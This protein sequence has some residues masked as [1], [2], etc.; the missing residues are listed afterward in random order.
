MKNSFTPVGNAS[1]QFSRRWSGTQQSAIDPYITGYHF[2]HFAYIPDKLVNS[3]RYVPDPHK[4]SQKN[5][6]KSILHSSCLS[7]TLPTGTLNKAEFVGLGGQKYAVPTNVE[8]DN[9]FTI[10]FL[11]YSG[12]P[13]LAIMHAWVR[14]IRDYRAGVSTLDA[15]E[16]DY[17]K[18]NYAATMFYWTTQPNGLYVEEFECLTGVYPLKDPRDQYGHDITTYDKL[19]LDIDFNV[20]VMWHED[21]VKKKCDEL[22]KSYW[23]AWG[24]VNGTADVNSYG[25][26]DAGAN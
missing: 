14:M 22:A 9:N 25:S 5:E 11:E 23:G 8:Y 21:W 3:V 1:N 17:T 19:E 24:G 15:N 2:I 12:T 4:I 18:S 10:K 7:V 13:I 16:E 6:I 20:D 26:G